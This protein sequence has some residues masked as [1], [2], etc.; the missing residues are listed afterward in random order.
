MR[1]LRIVPSVTANAVSGA[2]AGDPASITI[3]TDRYAGYSSGGPLAFQPP[4]PT[5]CNSP[6]GVT[7]AGISG[8]VGLGAQS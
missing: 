8:F 1:P 5:A 6:A 7:A 3:T 2:Q 4:D